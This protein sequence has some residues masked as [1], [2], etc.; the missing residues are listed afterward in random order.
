MVIDNTP[1]YDKIWDQVRSRLGFSPSSAYRGHSFSVPLPFQIGES[2][3]VYAIEDM[4]DDRIDLLGETMRD[5]FI[6][7]TR[8]GQ[9]IYALDWHHSAFLYDPRDISEQKSCTVKDERYKDGG[10][11]A[12]FPSFYPDGDYYFFIEESFE[13]GYLGHPWRQE[14]WIFGSELLKET[15]QVYQK[16]GWKKLK[17]D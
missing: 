15:E 5:I 3:S 9:R 13:F 6:R 14:I 1:E 2:Y 16:L 4:T 11:Q 12:Y 8:P 10:Y 17:L 7:I